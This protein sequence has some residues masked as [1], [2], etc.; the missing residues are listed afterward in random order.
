M[1]LP[2]LQDLSLWQ[3]IVLALGIVLF[4]ILMLIV[5]SWLTGG[6]VAA[7][8]RSAQRP[9]SA[10]EKHPF[11]LQPIDVNIPDCSDNEEVKDRMRS[12]VLE[13]LDQAL[14]DH[15]T[16]LFR[17]WMSNPADPTKAGTGVRNGARAY[18]HARHQI[19]EWDVP[20]CKK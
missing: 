16:N 6:D 19:S 4:A 12:L 10:E 15:V 14:R 7:Q 8:Q 9:V 20:P 13:G 3:R 2:Q 18:I 5:I 1:K 17:I 11:E